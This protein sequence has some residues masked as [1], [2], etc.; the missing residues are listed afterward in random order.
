MW[1][2]SQGGSRPPE[3]DVLCFF[4]GCFSLR[5]S[6]A[7]PPGFWITI[8]RGYHPGSWEKAPRLIQHES[9][10]CSGRQETSAMPDFGFRRGR[11][12]HVKVW[13]S[14]FGMSIEAK[15]NKLP[16]G[17]SQKIRRLMINPRNSGAQKFENR[18]LYSI[19]GPCCGLAEHSL[20]FQE[21]LQESLRELLQR[22]LFGLIWVGR[23]HSEN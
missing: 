19:F 5:R 13:G 1:P 15:E 3:P 11:V 10:W 22:L 4:V 7:N 9:L 23:C 17:R 14:E 8:V 12:F 18:K 6:L 20:Q 2:A 16:G 21:S